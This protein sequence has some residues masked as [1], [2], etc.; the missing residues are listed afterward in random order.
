M[1]ADDQQ[2]STSIASDGREL[3]KEW[4]IFVKYFPDTNNKVELIS[5]RFLNIIQPLDSFINPILQWEPINKRLDKIKEGWRRVLNIYNQEN[6]HSF[7]WELLSKAFY[8]S[9]IAG[10]F[11]GGLDSIKKST[12]RFELYKSGKNFGTVGHL[13]QRKM[14]FVMIQFY[15][16]GMLKGL[17]MSIYICSIVALTVG[18][19]AYRDRYSL[20][21][22]PVTIAL[23]FSTFAFLRGVGIHGLA[24]ALTVSFFPSFLLTTS[25]IGASFYSGFSVDDCYKNLRE[26]YLINAKE[27]LEEEKEIIR[28]LSSKGKSGFKFWVKYKMRL[29]KEMGT[30]DRNITLGDDEELLK[31]AQEEN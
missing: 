6:P 30:F 27:K 22:V 28:Y 24:M 9:F 2:P 5:Q 3:V 7:E 8:V 31:F 4:S 12:Q 10:I 16:N 26:Y 20:F 14:D 21:Y 19:T 23:V 25:T 17:S 15:K 13:M 11:T 18:I 29:E 1:L